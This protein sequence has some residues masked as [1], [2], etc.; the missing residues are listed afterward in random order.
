MRAQSQ[1]YTRQFKRSM[2][3]LFPLFVLFSFFSPERNF[4]ALPGYPMNPNYVAGT[5]QEVLQ[6]DSETVLY[7]SVPT[8]L[9]VPKEFLLHSELA[10]NTK[11]AR[12]SQ[13]IVSPANRGTYVKIR[14]GSSMNQE[15]ND[16]LGVPAIG[17][18][19]QSVAVPDKKGIYQ[20]RFLV[21]DT[22]DYIVET[23]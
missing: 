8:N 10:S 17:E 21:K 4:I 11:K 12:L 14:F 3:R 15:L 22:G 13:P 5:V 20:A 16:F 7:V 9:E 1:I 23:K 18:H 6:G 2:Y 19:V